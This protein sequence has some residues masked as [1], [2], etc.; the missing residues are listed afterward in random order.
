MGNDPAPGRR[1]AADLLVGGGEMGERTRAFDWSKT[2]LGPVAD[3]SQSLKTAVRIMLG[4]RYPMFIWWGRELTNLYNDAYIPML[5][6]R[7]PDALGRSAAATWSDIWDVVGPQADAVLTDGRST[8]NEELLLIMERNQFLEETYFTYSYSP[9]P[10]DAGGIG[11]VFCAVTED[12]GRVLGRRRLKT[13]RELGARTTEEGRTA[14]QACT[15]A[16]DT[17]HDNPNDVPFALLYLLDPDGRHARLAGATRLGAGTPASP[18]AVAVS[19]PAAP[20]PFQAAAE[21]GRGQ[22]V[23]LPPDRFGLLPGGAWPEPSRRA[24]VLPLAKLGQAV[25]TGFLVAG[26]SPRLVFDDDY[27]GF[28]ELAAGH[29]AAAVANARTYEEERK[30]AEALAEL[31]RAKTAFFSNVS[32]EF[33][34][35]LTLMLGPVED[36]IVGDGFD[37]PQAALGQLQVVNRNGQRLLKLVNTLL[38]FARIEAG[39]VQAVYEPTDLSALTADLASVFRSAVERAGLRLSVD[40]RPLPGPVYVDRDMWEKV[41]LNLLSNALKFTFEGSISVE[42]RQGSGDRG[43]ESG[44]G[45][46][47]SEVGSQR[48]E[49]RGQRSE[50]SSELRGSSGL[51]PDACLPTPDFRPLTSDLRPLTSDLRP[52]TPDSWVEL[53]VRDTGTGIPPDELPRLFERFHRVRDA[54]GR[55][56]EGSGIGLALV[57][58]LVKLHGGTIRAESTLGKGTTFVVT[59][60]LGTAHLPPDRVGGSRTLAATAVGAGPFVEEALRWLPAERGTRN[61]ERGTEEEDVSV[62]HSAFRVPRSALARVLVADDNADMR[63][64][65]VRLLAG[66]Y[67]VEAVADGA[68]ALAAARE[69]V[70]DL[71]LADVMMP[72]LDGFG[73]LKE[74]RADARTA[75]VP[76]ILLSARA[77][78]ESRVEGLDA[79]ADDYLVKPFSA[80]EMLSRVEAHLRLARVRREAGAALRESEERFARFMRHLPGL[81]WIKDRQGRYVYANEAAAAAFGTAA[82]ELYGKTD[83]EVFPAETAAL[84]RANDRAALADGSG[85]QVVE[86]LTHPDGTVHHSLVSKF[87]IPGPDGEPALTGGVAIDVTDRKRAEEALRE[88][89]E[90]FRTLADNISQFAWMADAKGWIF[91]Y[92]R[93]WFDYTGTTLEQMQGWGWKQVHHPD[94]A[95]DVVARIQRS[96]DTGEPWEDTFP[97][98]GRDGSYRWFL[99]RALP[100]RDAEGRVVRWFG[101]NTDVTEQREAEEALRDADRRKDEFLA[102]LA[103]ELRN[104]LAPIRNAIR[105]LQVAGPPDPHL[106][107]TREIIERQVRH[108]V[109]LIDDL[110]DVSRIT[111]GKLPLQRQRVELA[112]VVQAARETADPAIAAAG[113]E[114]T[115]ELPPEPVWLDADPTRLAQVFANLLTNA[116]KYTDRGGR[117]RLSAER[118]GDVVTVAVADTGIGIPTEHLPRLFEMFSQV[119][120]ARERSQGGLGIGLAL[121]RGLVEMHGGTIVAESPG[122]GRG[123]TFTVRLPVRNDEFGMMNDESKA[124]ETVPI[125]HSS[126]IIHHSNKVLV[127]DDN[128]DGADSLAAVLRAMGCEVRV[129]YDGPTGLEEA[130]RFK[131]DAV[132]CDIGMPGLSGLEVAR[133]LRADPA[134]RGARLIALTGWGHDDDRRRSRE[135]GFDRHLTKPV[136]PAELHKALARGAPAG[137]DP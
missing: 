89:E 66:R 129:A 71:V 19:G 2:P 21:A 116:A 32:H 4:S 51:T 101:T 122:A 42:V 76:I 35:P 109:R 132:V 136:D 8:W 15:V 22:V 103:H 34:T 68:A 50:V 53:R 114:L 106:T 77:G 37:L 130:A 23:D 58:E 18:A 7:H 26:L 111:R 79:G 104:P 126:F 36:L 64:H 62:L 123:S 137:A 39:R 82:A 127:I 124:T 16:A 131:P 12:T 85:G 20:W 73:L 6:Q 107:S 9:A 57:Q 61:A 63:E 99:S 87:P 10:D 134:L 75:G 135:A 30:R 41:V 78:E 112:A 72:R 55:T 118:D 92:N 110:L 48:S 117:I 69:R 115:V 46:R 97:L 17:L 3:W 108:M 47:K 60:P 113:H 93:R 83:E 38:D 67:E 119:A 33:R 27:R 125:H 44:V 25:P 81:A 49:V 128:R 29:V 14:E 94:H 80:R 121:V 91:W 24:V 105:I 65:L 13:L 54:R 100:I 5:G 90:R 59:V 1:P 40:C 52:L 96:W 133:R 120:P 43:Q 95:L 86:T 102:T 45:S 88:S 84:F 98:R 74:L 56:H 11:G 70:P 28:L 31:D